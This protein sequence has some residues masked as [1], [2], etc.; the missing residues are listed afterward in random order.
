M[1][2]TVK[3]FTSIQLPN[4][5]LHLSLSSPHFH[6][7]RLCF[8]KQRAHVQKPQCFPNPAGKQFT[9]D[10]NTSLSLLFYLNNKSKF[11]FSIT[12]ASSV[13]LNV[14]NYYGLNTCLF[15]S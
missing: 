5:P 15:P 14:L 1:I 6:L 3:A 10:Q 2:E 7:P 9:K 11:T 8:L 13:P 4:W 12:H